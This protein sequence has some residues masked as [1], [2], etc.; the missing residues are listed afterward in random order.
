MQ[1]VPADP[2]AAAAKT[3]T[4][5]DALFELHLKTREWLVGDSATQA[6]LVCYSYVARVTEG[7]FDFEA[8]P[9]FCAW[10]ARMEA[11]EGFAPM[12]HAADLFA[13]S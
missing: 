3:S 9:A 10:L 7:G 6:D 11:L 1:C 4:L 5:F 8:Y 12:V 2:D 13:K